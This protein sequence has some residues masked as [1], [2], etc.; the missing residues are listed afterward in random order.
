MYYILYN[1]LSISLKLE[2][3]QITLYPKIHQQID[4]RLLYQLV[5]F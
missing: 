1:E 3:F 5:I 2:I 4:T